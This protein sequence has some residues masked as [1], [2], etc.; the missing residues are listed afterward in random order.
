MI[1]EGKQ[2]WIFVSY[3]KSQILVLS[4]IK[5]VFYAVWR[6]VQKEITYVQNGE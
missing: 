5:I 2:L 1:Y 3:A 6:R 4:Y